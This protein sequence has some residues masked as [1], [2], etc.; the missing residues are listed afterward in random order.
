[1][2]ACHSSDISLAN[3]RSLRA[4]EIQDTFMLRAIELK[5][6]QEQ[7]IKDDPEC[8][9]LMNKIIDIQQKIVDGTKSGNQDTMVQA[10]TELLELQHNPKFLNMVIPTKLRQYYTSAV[11][12]IMM[13]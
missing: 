6:Q 7:L 9:V 12:S 13:Q 3:H 2:G 5:S 4:K 8:K 11:D 1:M 10:H